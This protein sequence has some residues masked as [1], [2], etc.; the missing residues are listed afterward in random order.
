MKSDVAPTTSP[1]ASTSPTKATPADVDS[2]ELRLTRATK[3]PDECPGHEHEEAKSHLPETLRQPRANGGMKVWRSVAELENTPEFRELVEREF[4]KA[5]SEWTD[6]VSRRNFMKIM[7]ASLALAG[8]TACTRRPDE[9]VVPYVVPPEQVIP[10]RPLFFATTYTM[11]GVGRGILVESHEG[12]PTKIEGNPDHPASLGAAS[13]HMQASILTMYDPDRSQA[14]LRLGDS[15]TWDRFVSEILPRLD[16]VRASNGDGLRILMSPVASPTV[17]RQLKSILA[18]YPGAKVHT[19]DATGRSQT[20]T[21]AK[22]AFGQDVNTVYKLDKANVVLSLDSNFLVDEGGS[23]VYA[24]QFVDGRRVRENHHDAA[25]MNRLYVVESTPTIT[26]AMA[27]HR[28]RVKPSKV[29]AF[30]SALLAKLSGQDADVT[31]FPW[32]NALVQDLQANRGKSVIVVG[33]YQTPEVHAIAHQIN[34]IL[35]N[36]GQ[37]VYYTDP[38]YSTVAT[39]TLKELVDDAKAEKV[40]LLF[41]LGPNPVYDAPVDLKFADTL[42]KVPFRVRLGM[43]NDETSFLCHWHI[44]ESH[45]LET[46]SDSRAYD[47]TASI[48]QPLIAPLYASKS[49]HEMLALIDGHGDFSDYEL[50]RQTWGAPGNPADPKLKEFEPKWREW[51]NKGVIAGTAYEARTFTPKGVG[52]ASVQPVGA[53]NTY[54]VVIRPDPNVLDGRFS[55][56]G[57]LQELPKP[58][59][60]LV[61]DNVILISPETAKKHGIPLTDAFDDAWGYYCDLKVGETKITGPAWIVPG[62]P[63]NT[64]TVFLGYGRK[65]GGVI[66]HDKGFDVNPIRTSANPWFLTG[67]E[68]SKAEG[69]LRMACTQQHQLMKGLEQRDL[70][71]VH[72]ITEYENAKYGP[73]GPPEGHAKGEGE[74]PAAAAHGEAT[75]APEGGHHGPPLDARYLGGTADTPMAKKAVR[76]VALTLYNQKMP[77]DPPYDQ[78]TNQWGMSIDN[79][80][81]IGCNACVV[82]CQSE[83]NIPIV[84][85]TEVIFGREMHWLRIDTYYGGEDVSKAEGP[86]FQPLPC[87][88]CESAPCEVVCPVEATQHDNEGLNVM[89]Y[90]RCVGTKYCSNNCPYK[91]RRFNFFRYKDD[92]NESIKLMR[93]PNVTIR[94]RGIMEKCTY[95]IQRISVARIEAKKT[96]GENGSTSYGKVEGALTPLTACQQSCPT[97]AIVF[98]S[99]TDPKA[100][101]VALKSEPTDYSLLEELNTRPRTTY[102][103]RFTNPNP[104]VPTEAKS[105]A[106]AHG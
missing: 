48:V 80:A 89:T 2:V 53:A 87:M 18:R 68:L 81:C 42:V 27:D 72:P 61:W 3:L 98:G 70:I 52:G 28:E 59:T 9:L 21:G 24:R 15:T 14:P 16:E 1:A 4:P 60:K 7:G 94:T 57:W 5:A 102:L 66:A 77:S 32:L 79:N 8:V 23:L 41:I 10:G 55:N 11:E 93:N 54:E 95:C 35:G 78:T 106:P 103:G 92:S 31:G 29:E 74:G 25:E 20:A 85:K 6:E 26:G 99:L 64:V 44:P 49:V 30:A 38:V 69:R 33:E 56:N 36:V 86:F 91:V 90:N 101:V 47:G 84:G 37:T 58:L 96:G 88:H 105:P 51:L 19:H 65:S 97:G 46:W 63:E 50:V 104:A 45:F 12:R 40:H 39:G 62:H 34:A 73:D 100:E 82:A 71:R 22:A 76:S 67:A 13:A 17:E 83:N 43:Y 75:A